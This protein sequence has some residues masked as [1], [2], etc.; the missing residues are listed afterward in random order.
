MYRY[1]NLL[2]L[3]SI[4]VAFDVHCSLGRS[5]SREMGKAFGDVIDL[6]RSHVLQFYPDIR[7]PRAGFNLSMRLVVAK[8]WK[9]SHVR[10]QQTTRS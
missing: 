10:I 6:P 3:H 5:T 2:S 7:I 4:C 8:A 1:C 9:I